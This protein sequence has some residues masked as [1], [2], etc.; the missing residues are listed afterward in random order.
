MPSTEKPTSAKVRVA[1]QRCRVR[2]IKCDGGASSCTNCSRAGVE[3]IDA[4][5]RY[6][7]TLIPR[8]YVNPCIQAILDEFLFQLNPHIIYLA[9]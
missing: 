2:R 7:D 1:C 8:K 3:C 5:A 9:Q 4:D 6:G